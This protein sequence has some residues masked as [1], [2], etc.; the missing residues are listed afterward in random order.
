MEEKNNVEKLLSNV[1]EYA[2]VRFDL[3]SLNFQ[4]KLSI[5]V[6]SLVSIVIISVLTLLIFLFASIGAALWL[7]EYF[8]SASIG[9]FCVMGFYVLLTFLLLLNREK[10]IKFP[11]MNSLIKK[12]N[13][14]DEN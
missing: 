12:I 10:W 2:E 5:V 8:Q 4:D 6:S 14:N 1:K 7:G 13:F 11:I 9:F 3:I